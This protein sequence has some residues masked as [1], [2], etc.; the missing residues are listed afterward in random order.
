MTAELSNFEELLKDNLLTTKESLSEPNILEIGRGVKELTISWLY[1]YFLDPNE[2]SHG[3]GDLFLKSFLEL[4]D[5]DIRFG[6]TTQIKVLREVKYKGKYN[7]VIIDIVIKDSKN[8]ILIENKLYADI[9]NNLKTYQEY[10]KQEYNAYVI[11]AVENLPQKIGDWHTT[12]HQKLFEKVEKNY[13]N[14]TYTLSER[15]RVN[16]ESFIE[17]LKK[18][19]KIVENLSAKVKFISD[20]SSEITNLVRLINELQTSYISKISEIA[21]EALKGSVKFTIEKDTS[22]NFK[23]NGLS[24]NGYIF[25]SPNNISKLILSI[26]IADKADWVSEWH[27]EGFGKFSEIKNKFDSLNAVGRENNNKRWASM[28]YKEYDLSIDEFEKLE[29]TFRTSLDNEWK[30]LFE[31]LKLFKD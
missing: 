6:D 24:L 14:N 19:Y 30:P 27:S 21:R 18:H 10:L 25:F 2:K 4:K 28:F 5:F 13:K 23:V 31:D 9:Y 7:T 15:Q 17:I 22:I 11:L 29:G 8:T 26:W 12:T 20:K 3:L 1:A 16:L